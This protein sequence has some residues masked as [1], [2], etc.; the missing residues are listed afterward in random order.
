MTDDVTIPEQASHVLIVKVSDPVEV[1]TR[2]GLSE[3]FTLAQNGQPGKSGLEAF[4][5]DFLEETDIVSNRAAPFL[6]VVTL[7][8][9]MVAYTPTALCSIICLD[10]PARSAP[11]TLTA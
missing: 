9:L 8:I 10:Y 11:A 4:Q 5:A 6:I 1:E 2:E 3:A 7:V